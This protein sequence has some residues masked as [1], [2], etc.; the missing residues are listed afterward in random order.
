MSMD[1]DGVIWCG[2]IHRTIHRYDPRTAAIESV[3]L[4]NGSIASACICAGRKVYI[5]GEDYPKLVVYDRTSKTFTERA[6]GSSPKP[7]VWYGTEAIDGRHLFLFDRNGGVVKWDTEKD[8]G[9]VLPY[10]SPR[11][12]PRGGGYAPP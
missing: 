5:L 12:M 1:A 3:P 10:P 7:D 11:H 9:E 2:S 6:Y 4:P 8:A